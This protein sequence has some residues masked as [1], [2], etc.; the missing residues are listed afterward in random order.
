MKRKIKLC[1]G[2]IEDLDNYFPYLYPDGEPMK[3]KDL[4]IEEVSIGDCNNFEENL[5]RVPIWID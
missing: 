2:C 5:D 3:R 1:R 4:E